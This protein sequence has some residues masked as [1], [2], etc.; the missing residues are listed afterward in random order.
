MAIGQTIS[1][2]EFKKRY[3]GQS[4]GFPSEAPA[5]VQRSFTERVGRIADTIF[6]GGKVGEAI[7]GVYARYIDPQGR[8]LAQMDPE[9]AKQGFGGFGGTGVTGKEIAGSALK[10]AVSVGAAALPGAGSLVGKIAQGATLGYASDVAGKLE[11]NKVD[12]SPSVGTVVGAALPVV[13]KALGA[14]TRRT[15]GTTSGAG[16]PVIKRA[17]EN[18]N[19]VNAAIRTYAKDE[20]SKQALVERTKSAI[21]EYLNKRSQ[22]FGEGIAQT[23][24]SK[25]FA[26]QEILTQFTDELSKFKGSVKNGTLTFNS[27]KLTAA[28]KADIKAFYQGLKEWTD[29]TPSGIEDLRQFIGNNMDDFAATKNSRASVVLGNLKKFVTN[30]LEERSP[31]YKK[32]LG[33]YGK[34]TQLARD[35]LAELSLKSGNA[36]PSTQLN[37]IMRIFKKDPKI[38]EDLTEIMGPDEANR[39]LN[40]VSGA[41]LS[42]ALPS[43]MTRQIIEGGFTLG[44]LFSLFTGGISLPTLIGGAATASPRLVGEASTLAGKAIKK[45]VGTGIRR[46]TTIGASRSSQ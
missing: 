23:T 32:I 1:A 20:S 29:F 41:I 8:R 9:F 31:G 37:S 27:S 3:G 38:I 16:N 21:Q 42:D 35:T 19:E 26:K 33:D 25:P 6:G 13:T 34:K 4:S 44:G 7:G 15:L 11:Q 5:Q 46:A 12:L 43:G 28:D 14:L 36:K 2:E 40:E 30:G 17:V 18:P 39:L 45:G 22:V 10:G 24:F